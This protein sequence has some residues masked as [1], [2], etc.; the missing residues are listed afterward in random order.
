MSGPIIL[1][2]GLRPDNL[3]PDPLGLGTMAWRKS[4]VCVRVT[5]AVSDLMASDGITPTEIFGAMV[6]N[7]IA[8]LQA[9]FSNAERREVAQ[10]VCDQI[11]RRM[12]A[13]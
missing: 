5:Q 2:R 10:A 3:G 4:N 7:V 8:A 13:R 6:E 12:T 1:P 9:G 11:M